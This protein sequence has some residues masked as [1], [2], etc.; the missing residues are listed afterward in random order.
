VTVDLG[1]NNFISLGDGAWSRLGLDQL[2]VTYNTQTAPDGTIS[3][4]KTAIVAKLSVG[5]LLFSQMPVSQTNTL[6]SQGDGRIGMG[7]FGGFNFVI[8]QKAHKIWLFHLSKPVDEP[9]QGD[10]DGKAGPKN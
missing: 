7:F 1:D 4:S 5:P 10:K 8:D 2:A 9:A 3:P 6:P